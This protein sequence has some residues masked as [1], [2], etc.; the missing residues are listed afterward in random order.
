M[1]K[2]AILDLIIEQ[3]EENEQFAKSVIMA[4]IVELIKKENDSVPDPTEMK[5]KLKSGLFV[6]DQI[7]FLDN[8][9]DKCDSIECL[10]AAKRQRLKYL[11]QLKK[12]TNEL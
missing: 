1:S 3:S 6:V 4:G 12:I 10:K 2:Q 8:E 7:L 11:E 9:M 5:K